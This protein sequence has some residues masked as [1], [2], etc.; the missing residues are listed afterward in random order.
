MK[1]P[2][3]KS[4]I[5]FNGCGK[6]QWNHVPR[7]GIPTRERC[8]SVASENERQHAA[9]LVQQ[10]RAQEKIAA[11]NDIEARQRSFDSPFNAPKGIHAE[12]LRREMAQCDHNAFLAA[13]DELTKLRGQA[14]ALITPFLKRL[15][16]SFD[17]ALNASALEAEKRIEAETLPVISGDVWILHNDGV[18]QA[19]WFRRVKAQKTLDEIEPGNSVGAV[20]YFLSNEE[21]T[22]FNWK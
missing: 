16:E 11:D 4:K 14:V 10:F 8:Q 15:V 12:L 6:W 18:C 19:L 3:A 20:Q 5:P 7:G 17:E 21:F 9:K 22:P 2:N 1:S 13:Q